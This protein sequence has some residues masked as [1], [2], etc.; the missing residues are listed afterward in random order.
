MR[1]LPS[2]I[3]GLYEASLD[4][5]AVPQLLQLLQR[6]FDSQNATF[7]FVD[8]VA[9]QGV[10]QPNNIPANAAARYLQESEMDSRVTTVRKRSP[11]T[12]AVLEADVCDQRSFRSDYIYETYFNPYDMEWMMAVGCMDIAGCDLYLVLNRSSRVP[13]FDDQDRDRLWKLAPYV[14]RMLRISVNR[15]N[16][17]TL[18]DQI[19]QII[20]DAQSRLVRANDAADSILRS[21]CI[22]SL[23]RGRLVLSRWHASQQALFE[24]M[25]FDAA[26]L[27]QA[28]Q[29]YAPLSL[30]D[31][32]NR[33]YRISAHPSVHVDDLGV[34]QHHVTILIVDM[35]VSEALPKLSQLDLTDSEQDVL[36]LF[37]AGLP[38]R[39]IAKKRSRSIH[40]VR[41]QFKAIMR[42]CSVNTQAEL[43]R[44]LHRGSSA[45]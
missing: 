14:E 10:Y 31:D 39:E 34:R 25:V 2:L 5:Q 33:H 20:V 18:A 44:F 32:T 11:S 45:T 9:D 12:F 40:T 3:S 19:P 30:T 24:R 16:E 6:A 41:T 27:W 38:M 21:E 37:L 17:R 22:V 4:D 7:A 29:S 8:R 23:R 26:A 35:Q 15:R 1:E 28:P 42:K 36:Q 43:V 13:E